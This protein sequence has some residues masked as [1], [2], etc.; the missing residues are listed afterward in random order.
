MLAKVGETFGHLDTLINNAGTTATWKVKDLDSLDMDAWD[1]TFA[2]NVRGNFQV[3]ARKRWRCSGR[4]RNKAASPA[5]STPP[6]S[7]AC[8]PARSH[9]PT[10]PVRLRW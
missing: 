7:W 10:P 4:A 2:V 9:R 6:A 3:T 5:S 1:R 8:V